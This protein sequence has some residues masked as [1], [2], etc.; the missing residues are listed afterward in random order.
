[1]LVERKDEVR[2]Y[3]ITY[4]VG[5]AYTTA[6]INSIRDSV[7]ALVGREGGEIVD[8]QDW[9]KKELA[10][11]IKKDGKRYNEALYTHLVVKLAASR[12]REVIRAIELKREVI[13]SLMIE[14]E[15]GQEGQSQAK[16]EKSEE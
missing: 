8:T 1:M 4:L 9:G 10:Y 13:R 16:E 2:E 14:R 7:V 12:A 3:E 5:S 11:V 15:P 6:E